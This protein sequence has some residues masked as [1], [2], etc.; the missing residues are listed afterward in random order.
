MKCV[1]EPRV[2]PQLLICIGMRGYDLFPDGSLLHGIIV[3]DRSSRRY[4]IAQ[5]PTKIYIKWNVTG[6]L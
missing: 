5:E 4:Q 6:R 2:G 3:R 1:S